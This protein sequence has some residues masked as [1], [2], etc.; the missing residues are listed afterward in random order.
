M[1]NNV[2]MGISVEDNE[3]GE[4]FGKGGLASYPW[5]IRS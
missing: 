2:L 5:G 3:N 1:M 4:L